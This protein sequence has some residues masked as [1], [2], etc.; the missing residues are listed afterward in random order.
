MQWISE[1]LANAPFSSAKRKLLPLGSWQQSQIGCCISW[2]CQKYK[3]EVDTYSQLLCLRTCIIV[4]YWHSRLLHKHCQ[5]I[6]NT[7][8]NRWK[9]TNFNSPYDNNQMYMSC[10]WTKASCS[11]IQTN[12]PALRTAIVSQQPSEN[13]CINRVTKS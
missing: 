2:N 1:F 6:T 5:R 13:N 10:G 3:V 11:Y 12:D 4:P 8:R 9:T 7:D